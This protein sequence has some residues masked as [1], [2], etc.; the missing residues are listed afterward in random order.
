M[1]NDKN[2]RKII[3]FT[4]YAIFVTKKILKLCTLRNANSIGTK[5]KETTLLCDGWMT[6]KQITD[7]IMAGNVL[8]LNCD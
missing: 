7:A 6:Q 3:T 5:Q 2:N 1:A 8:S 4:F